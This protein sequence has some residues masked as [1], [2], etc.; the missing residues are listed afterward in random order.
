MYIYK[1]TYIY[2]Y[3]C[4]FSLFI[5]SPHPLHCSRSHLSYLCLTKNTIRFSRSFGSF[6]ARSWI[7]PRRKLGANLL[8]LVWWFKLDGPPTPKCPIFFVFFS[9]WLPLVDFFF[10]HTKPTEWTWKDSKKGEKKKA[11]FNGFSLYTHKQ[12]GQKF[13][14]GQFFLLACKKWRPLF[15]RDTVVTWSVLISWL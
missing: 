15:R 2:I 13:S 6:S 5:V 4:I 7:I 9:E 3:M 12:T 11:P 10:H 1:Y 8:G 14:Y